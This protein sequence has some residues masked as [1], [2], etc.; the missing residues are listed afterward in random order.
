MASLVSSEQENLINKSHKKVSPDNA[1][2]EFE[3][4]MSVNYLLTELKKCAIEKCSRTVLV[5]V[6]TSNSMLNSH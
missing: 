4:G 2:R 5:T 6:A 3:E 1:S